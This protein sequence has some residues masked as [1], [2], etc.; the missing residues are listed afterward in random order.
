[1]CAQEKPAV[2]PSPQYQMIL[3]S[4]LYRAQKRGLSHLDVKAGDLCR[5]FGGHTDAPAREISNWCRA[6]QAEKKALDV[7]IA[8]PPEGTGANLIIRYKLPRTRM[9]T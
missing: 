8:E 4:Q 3:R 5:R 2:M 6:M 9:P 1:M 7:V